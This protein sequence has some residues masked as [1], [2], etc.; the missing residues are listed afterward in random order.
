MASLEGWSS[1]IELH[2]QGCGKRS[3]TLPTAGFRRAVRT[4]GTT[5]AAG[6]RSPLVETAHD[7][8]EIAVLR[9]LVPERDRVDVALEDVGR[10][11]ANVR[12]GKALVGVLDLNATVERLA[13]GD[14]EQLS[15]PSRV[16][17]A[18]PTAVWATKSSL[19]PIAAPRWL[20]QLFVA[21]SEYVVELPQPASASVRPAA[22][23]MSAGRLTEPSVVVPRR[24][25]ISYRAGRDD[26]RR[27]ARALRGGSRCRW[28]STCS[29]AR[30]ARD[31]LPGRACAD[32]P[33]GRSRRLPAR[34]A[35]RGRLLQRSA[36]ASRPHQ[37]IRP[38]GDLGWSPPWLVDR[39]DELGAEG[40][41]LLGVTG[42]PAPELYADLDGDR[43]AR[44]RMRAL[45]EASLRLSGGV[46]NW[47]VV[48]Y[49][50]DEGA[51]KDLRR[52]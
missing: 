18:P 26:G 32:G 9:M 50:T 38:G 21:F 22:V 24:E 41:A 36:R 52:A 25:S 42:N 40:D 17:N 43:V 46:C 13:E 14:R 8:R 30:A 44:S 15:S 51:D 4:P 29:P 49:P 5:G 47:S 6:S 23:A 3:L 35:L 19:P 34:R 2:P 7:E 31:Q 33:R 27:E 39:L 48:A 1:T 11:G 16:T 45:S 20:R 28:A 10:T 12:E 37:E